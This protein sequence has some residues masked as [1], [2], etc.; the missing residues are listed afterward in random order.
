VGVS[1]ARNSFFFAHQFPFGAGETLV[2][3]NPQKKK[4]KKNPISYITH[5]CPKTPIHFSHN[6]PHSCPKKPIHFS[7]ACT[8][9]PLHFSHNTSIPARKEKK[10]QE[11][12][13]IIERTKK[14][15]V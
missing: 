10:G 6:C 13:K 2:I 15:G 8:N 9:N 14:R 5:T 4:E 7:F 3:T 12:K 11:M 1:S